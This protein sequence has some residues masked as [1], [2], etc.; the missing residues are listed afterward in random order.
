MKSTNAATQEKMPGDPPQAVVLPLRVSH[1]LAQPTPLDT[2]PARVLVLPILR[3]ARGPPESPCPQHVREE[4]CRL[5][6]RQQ[7]RPLAVLQNRPPSPQQPP[8]PRLPLPGHGGLAPSL[9][10]QLCLLNLQH[11]NL[12]SVVSL[13]WSDLQLGTLPFPIHNPLFFSHEKM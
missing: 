10:I 4:R 13:P 9:L 8:Q 11:T 3:H 6:G 7:R 5:L 12:R 2:T 1:P